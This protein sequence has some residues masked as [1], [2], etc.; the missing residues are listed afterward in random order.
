MRH[1]SVVTRPGLPLRCASR[2]RTG[3]MSRLASG[4]RVEPD[5]SPEQATVR[6]FMEEFGLDVAVDSKFATFSYRADD[7]PVLGA[8][9]IL[10][11]K[12]RIADMVIDPKETESIVWVDRSVLQRTLSYGDHDYAVLKKYFATISQ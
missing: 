11:A 4:G 1:A 8:T 6:E 7:T 5:E 12:S 9:F 2:V 3:A 10:S